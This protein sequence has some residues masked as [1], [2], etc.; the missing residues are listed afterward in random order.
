M[1][2]LVK[3]TIVAFLA[4]I[5]AAIAFACG[6]TQNPGGEEKP[7]S[8]KLF[9]AYAPYAVEIRS[10]ASAGSGFVAVGEGDEVFIISCFHVA[11]TAA[12][13]IK[14]YGE[15]E[16]LSEKNTRIVGY[17]E[18]TDVIVYKTTKSGFDGKGILADGRI[19][20]VST[21][22]EVSVIASPFADG[23]SYLGAKI[24]LF[25]DVKNI[26]GTNRL[27]TRISGGI[28]D[29]SSGGMAIDNDGL[30]VGT[31]VGRNAEAS[32][33]DMCYL[34]PGAIVKAVYDAIRAG[35][36]TDGAGTTYKFEVVRP[37][38]SVSRREVATD[39]VIRDVREIVRESG[40]KSYRFEQVGEKLYLLGYE[41][42]EGR[43]SALTGGTTPGDAR[44]AEVTRINGAAIGKTFTETVAILL[45]CG[46][47]DFRIEADGVT[48]NL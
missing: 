46:T 13:Q 1:K 4:A 41:V 17:D 25:E 26:E 43:L 2:K 33:N 7:A 34:T 44:G 10:G 16:Y 6:G 40:G 14:F 8:D 21:G 45:G 37:D 12:P 29:G 48:L 36:I 35:K 38:F 15:T 3:N 5:I 18:K 9:A 39:N 30:L 11:K 20:A 28:Y 24:S 42:S 27:V 19:S 22:A 47:T 31:A 23:I 32:G